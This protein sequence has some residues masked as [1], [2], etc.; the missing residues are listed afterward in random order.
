MARDTVDVQDLC[1]NILA[2]GYAWFMLWPDAMLMFVESAAW[3]HSI[4]V[5]FTDIH[6]HGDD[7]IFAVFILGSV[8]ICVAHVTTM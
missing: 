3:F 2:H 8:L 6:H 7:Q 4:Y 1:C 5:D